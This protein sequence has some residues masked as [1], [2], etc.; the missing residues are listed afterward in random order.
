MIVYRKSCSVCGFE[1]GFEVLEL[2]ST[3]GAPYKRCP[4]CSRR[5]ELS[6]LLSLATGLFSLVAGGW[7]AIQYLEGVKAIFG[8]VVPLVPFL[9]VFIVGILSTTALNFGLSF[10]IY[11]TYGWLRSRT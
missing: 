9:G 10:L 11:A 5:V 4:N 6:M 2:A 1:V 3:Y 8:P 7:A